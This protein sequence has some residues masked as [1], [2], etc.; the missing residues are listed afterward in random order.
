MSDNTTVVVVVRDPDASND[1]RTFGPPVTTV[2]IDCGYAD[3]SD[4]EEYREWR[5][6]H[7]ERAAQL[8]AQGHPEAA[9]FIRETVDQYAPS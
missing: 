8:E 6:G 7:Y 2:D 5:E 4:A 9:A 3:L 1:Y